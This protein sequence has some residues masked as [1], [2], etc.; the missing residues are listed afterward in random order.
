MLFLAFIYYFN[1]IRERED[2]KKMAM[3]Q[4]KIRIPREN[5]EAERGFDFLLKILIAIVSYFTNRFAATFLGLNKKN[6][7]N[8]LFQNNK[9]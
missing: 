9:K 5:A 3:D 7:W 1:T 2:K 4:G 6:F 8:V